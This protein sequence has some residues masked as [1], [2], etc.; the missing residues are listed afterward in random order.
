MASFAL[1]SIL[2]LLGLAGAFSAEKYVVHQHSREHRRPAAWKRTTCGSPS[3]TPPADII[4]SWGQTVTPA[5]VHPEYPRPQMVRGAPAPGPAPADSWVNLNGLWEHELGS[6]FADPVPFGRTLNN[7]ILV[8][9]P[10]EACLSGAFAWPA[11]SSFF[12]YRLLFDA[13]FDAASSTLLHFGAVDWNVTVFLNGAAI[14]THSG[15]FAPFSFD[16]S[17]ALKP[18]G[19]ELI[20]QVYDPSD[21]GF[22]VNGKQRITA[23]S[24]PGGDTYTPSSGVWG[25]VWLE[26]APASAYITGLKLRGSMTSLFITVSTSSKAS[27]T[28]SGS[29]TLKG[30]AVTT[31]SGATGAEIVVPIPS[32]SLWHP[33]HPT[34]YDVQVAAT[35]GAST[36]T[37]HSYF[38]M[39]EVGKALFST[40]GGAQVLRPTLNGDFTFF[41][42]FLDQSWWSDGEYTAPT[43]DALAFD[44]QIV[45]DLGM[46]MIRLHQKVNPQRWYWYADTLGVVVL[47][48]MVQKYGGASAA[49][50]APFM[51]ELKDMIDTVYSHPSIF[52]W[53]V[54]NEGDCVRVFNATAAVEWTAQY[55]PSR[56]VDTNSG[57]P[58]NNL[59]IG[60]VNDVHSYPYPGNPAPSA[61]QVAMVGEFGGI[62]TYTT[63]QHEWANGQ[64][65]TYLHVNNATVYEETYLGMLATVTKNRDTTGLSY[66]V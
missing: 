58:A 37:V 23:I 53:T 17:S 57:G 63:G 4:T 60:D 10:L 7:T 44:L 54:F 19:N 15:G 20:L 43:D 40:P 24:H 35:V 36:D 1:V 62:G 42:G 21:H 64:C 31:F 48:D 50:V 28:V 22:Q 41:S 56:L 29:V 47:Q 9:F 5:N 2:S 51:Q 66:C 52:Q 11:Y 59:H 12:W 14:G 45:K 30:A 6:S 65:H 25:T 18:T 34:L 38:G 26:K 32:P 8:P 3:S 46:N 49:T 61:T 33:D 13:P 55:D 39:R 27:G 16:V